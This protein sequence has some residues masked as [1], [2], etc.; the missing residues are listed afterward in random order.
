MFYREHL[1]K[2]MFS[3][4]SYLRRR[5]TPKSSDS[6]TETINFT[7][8]NHEF[9]HPKRYAR[10]R[11]HESRKRW[12]RWYALHALTVTCR[13][14]L[15]P[16]CKKRRDLSSLFRVQSPTFF[17]GQ[18]PAGSSCSSSPQRH[19]HPPCHP[20]CRECLLASS[21]SKVEYSICCVF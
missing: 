2:P 21:L 12:P 4:R 11:P 20:P 3:S 17:M 10:Q 7:L 13:D 9:T 1:H 6:V 19:P 18:I 14:S 5:V 15:L 8:K 16:R